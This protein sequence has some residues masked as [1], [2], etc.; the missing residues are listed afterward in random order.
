MTAHVI[1]IRKVR[2]RVEVEWIKK[3]KLIIFLQFLN[4]MYWMHNF[5]LKT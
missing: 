4:P 3:M 2:D 1:G 5:S